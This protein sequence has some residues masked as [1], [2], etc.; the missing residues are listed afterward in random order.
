MVNLPKQT[1]PQRHFYRI[2]HQTPS[3]PPN[4][5][6]LPSANSS[7]R[8]PTKLEGRCVYMV[9]RVSSENEPKNHRSLNKYRGSV[10]VR[11]TSARG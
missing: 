3:L 4:E 2:W 10:A 9:P 6:M 8:L 7:E 1:E 11:G 5:L